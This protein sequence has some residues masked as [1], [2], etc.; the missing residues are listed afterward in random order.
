[1]RSS[2]F[3]WHIN[4]F[5]KHTP[6]LKKLSTD[7]AVSSTQVKVVKRTELVKLSMHKS[8][9]KLQPLISPRSRAGVRYKFIQTWPKDGVLPQQKPLATSPRLRPQ[10]IVS[11]SELY[12]KRSTE[13]LWQTHNRR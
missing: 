12:K 13:S 8:D 9:K 1:M 7:K 10:R 3:S 2:R 11:A 6:F 4:A 5:E